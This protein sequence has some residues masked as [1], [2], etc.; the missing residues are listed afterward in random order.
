MKFKLY[1]LNFVKS[2]KT[3]SQVKSAPTPAGEPNVRAE[4]EKRKNI[5]TP[6]NAKPCTTYKHLSENVKNKKRAAFRRA[7]IRALPGQK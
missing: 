1:V 7:S 6:K 2:P 5:C 4:A 3:R